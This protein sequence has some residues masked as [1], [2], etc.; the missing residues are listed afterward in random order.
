MRLASENAGPRWLKLAAMLN[1]GQHHH[2][3]A[4]PLLVRALKESSDPLDQAVA[5]ASLG[6][7]GEKTAAADIRPFLTNRNP[8]V[9]AS[10]A[11]AVGNLKDEDSVPVLLKLLADRNQEKLHAAI[12][13]ALSRVGTKP[14]RD[15]LV[16]AVADRKHGF[17][18]RRWAVLTLGE[19]RYE[20]AAPVLIKVLAD[21]RDDSGIRMN[22]ISALASLGGPDAWAAIQTAAEGKDKSLAMS[23][24]QAMGGSKDPAQIARVLDIAAKAGHPQRE[25]A[26][27][28]I[29]YRKLAGAGATLRTAI[30][31]ASTPTDVRITAAAALKAINEPFAAEDWNALWAAY[32]RERDRYARARLADA[33]IEAGFADKGRI[34]SLINELDDDKNQAWYASVKLLRHLS[35]QKFGPENE[36][37]GDKKSRR[38]EFDK[39]RKWWAAQAK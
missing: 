2:K 8:T 13:K 28:Q 16:G 3:P 7:L 30:R 15:G 10:A 24:V 12:C 17:Q 18:A 39:W 21:P 37:S 25:T 6:E 34:S 38:A 4:L 22:V 19:S 26:L 23:A 11:D 32:E 36:F 1:L 29:R 35:G 27:N 14:A 9:G 33:L 31:D 5:I 20:E